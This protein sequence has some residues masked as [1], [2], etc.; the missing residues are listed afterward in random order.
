MT[1]PERI[2]ASPSVDGF[3]DAVDDFD[4]SSSD[5]APYVR[6][7][8]YDAAAAERDEA[9]AA[10]AKLQRAMTAIGER[11]CC[12]GDTPGVYECDAQRPC[13]GCTLRAAE[14][15]CDEARRLLAE[16]VEARDEAM[17]EAETLERTASLLADEQHH[18]GEILGA[19]GDELVKV[20]HAARRVVEERDAARA[21]VERMRPVVEAAEAYRQADRM[22]QDAMRRVNDDPPHARAV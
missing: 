6:A 9:R 15:E 10:L 20:E 17:R 5:M 14:T 7:G 2:W 4:A 3:L 21:E 19:T 16:A 18:I 12:M 1:A 13:L 11:E 8:L 22:F